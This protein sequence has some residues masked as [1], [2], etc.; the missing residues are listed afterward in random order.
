VGTA[1][2]IN[3][4]GAPSNADPAAP[5]LVI[6]PS[7]SEVDLTDLEAFARGRVMQAPEVSGISNLAGEALTIGGEAAY[8]LIGDGV[9]TES[10]T[11]L[12]VFQ[13]VIAEGSH[14][15][16][17]HGFVGADRAAEFIPEFKAVARSLRRTP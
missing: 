13:V 3:D 5:L 2:L 4:S 6:A 10:S 14:Y 1:V 15:L 8:E 7:I 17:V 11:P 12:K 9:D 16:L